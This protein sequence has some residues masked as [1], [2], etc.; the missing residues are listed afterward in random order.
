MRKSSRNC[1]DFNNLR[2]DFFSFNLN[3][4]IEV[5]VYLC[6]RVL[7]AERIFGQKRKSIR[8]SYENDEFLPVRLSEFLNRC[9]DFKDSHVEAVCFHQAIERILIHAQILYF[10]GRKWKQHRLLVNFNFF[11]NCFTSHKQKTNAVCFVSLSEHI[12]KS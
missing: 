5:T 9:S 3:F 10:N 7:I 6:V 2:I 4:A 1:S 12:A 11:S 8:I